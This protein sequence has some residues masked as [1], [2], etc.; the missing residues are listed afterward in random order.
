LLATVA[1]YTRFGLGIFLNTPHITNYNS[2]GVVVD[3]V[4]GRL[5]G[6]LMVKVTK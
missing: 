5:F 3:D 6:H 1:A 4:V 2:G